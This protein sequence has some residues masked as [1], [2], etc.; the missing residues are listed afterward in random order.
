[1]FTGINHIGLV[2]RDIEPWVE[3]L[4]KA[5]GMHETRRLDFL[6]MGQ[7]SCLMAFG[8]QEAFELMMPLNED[9][10]V[11]KYLERFGEGIHHI[12]LKTSN[13]N[14]DAARLTEIG[15][16][17]FGETVVE[18]QQMAFVHPK[19]SLGILYELAEQNN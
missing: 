5:F 1:M 18:G 16:K 8:D 12:S 4:T 10:V 17:V 7:R 3:F 19:T 15:I 14:S 6:E 2:V 13:I 11:G 9:G